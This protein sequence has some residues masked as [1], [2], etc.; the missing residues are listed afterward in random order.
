VRAQ[1]VGAVVG[2][3]GGKPG[4]RIP[5][6]PLKIDEEREK[7][8]RHNWYD[9]YPPSEPDFTAA[10]KEASQTLIRRSTPLKIESRME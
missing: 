5:I 2:K 9:I 8:Y 10:Y 7:V 3:D 1:V 6:D 4:H